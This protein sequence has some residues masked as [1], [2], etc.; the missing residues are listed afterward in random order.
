MSAITAIQREM[1]LT[2]TDNGALSHASTLDACLDLF[3]KLSACRKDTGMAIRLFRNAYR[4]NPELALRILFYTRDVRGGQGERAVFRSVIEDLAQ[5]D[6]AV[7]IRLI[8]L[9]AEYGRWDDLMC[10]D[11]TPV[12]D[13]VLDL[14]RTQL[15]ADVQA[16]ENGEPVSLMAKWLPSAN[17]SSHRTVRLAR[18]IVSH[19]GW[20]ER[21]YRKTL[22]SLRTQ[23][24]IIEHAM[25]SGDWSSIDYSHVP[26]KAMN[27]YRHAFTRRDTKRFQEYLA[28]VASGE[29]KINS[30]TLYPYDLVRP[31]LLNSGNTD[32]V[33]DLQWDAL[34]NYCDRPFNGLVVADVSG[35]MTFNGGLPLAV[36]ISLAMYIAERNTCD[37][38]RNTFLTFSE[39]PQLCQITGATLGQR[40]ANLSQAD[41]GMNTD[42]QSVFD[43]VLSAAQRHQ[44]PQDE[45]PEKLI[46]VSDM[47]F[48]S[49]M[50]NVTNYQA[51][52]RKYAEAGYQ[53]PQVVFWNVNAR[54]DVP[55]TIHETGAVLV[56]GCSPAILRSVLNGELLT[57]QDVLQDAVY[58][59]RYAAVGAALSG[60]TYTWKPAVEAIASTEVEDPF[61]FPP[62][63]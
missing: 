21:Q 38:F 49:A 25:C 42:L 56:S 24:R 26:A 15:L 58:C 16:L 47:Q 17:A 18:A 54:S 19:L 59:D 9:F 14:V 63:F 36:S 48:D 41:W 8:P 60:A 27:M 52:Q 30:G 6:A 46:I 62:L 12:W 44:V 20:N 33:L 1:N 3:G 2:S 51:I 35:S 57:A 31:Y 45:M 39:Q 7:V 22:V 53:A 13:S 5:H 34:P 11:G 28:S 55:F 32:Q 37:A 23:L 50:S 29:A 10:L 43:T 40:V 61:D 4:D